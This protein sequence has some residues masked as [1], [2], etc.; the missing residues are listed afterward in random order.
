LEFDND[1]S[2]NPAGGN[3]TGGFAGC[4]IMACANAATI[5]GAHKV[6]ISGGDF[7]TSNYGA[8]IN[9]AAEVTLMGGQWQTGNGQAVQ[10]LSATNVIIDASMFSRPRSTTASFCPAAPASSLAPISPK[11][12]SLQTASKTGRFP[13]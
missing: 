10:V 7:S 4:S 11:P 5:T 2:T 3:F 12:S 13:I 9:G 1:P 8:I 6:K